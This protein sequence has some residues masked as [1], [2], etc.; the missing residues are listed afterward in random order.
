MSGELSRLLDAIE[1]AEAD[2]AAEKRRR[3]FRFGVPAG[4]LLFAVLL[5]IGAGLADGDLQAAL[6]AIA[7]ILGVVL[8]FSVPFWAFEI[9]VDVP[10]YEKRL[11]KARRA[12]RDYLLKT[13]GFP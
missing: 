1:E 8:L 13:G 12:H 11:R 10:A 2:L 7:A 6:G 3:A 5:G 4:V 9:D